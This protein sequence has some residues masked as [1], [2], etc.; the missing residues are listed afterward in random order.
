[1][2]NVSWGTRESANQTEPEQNLQKN[3]KCQKL[4][5]V[6]GYS[7]EF[8]MNKEEKV[9]GAMSENELQVPLLN[10]EINM[11]IQPKEG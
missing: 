9:R 4:F 3:V 10:P 1:M 11:P 7:F 2:N 5:K 8:Q 6:C